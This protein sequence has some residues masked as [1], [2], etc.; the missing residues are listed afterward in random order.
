MSTHPQQLGKYEMRE[1][2]GRG[3]MAE[4]W[5]AF[6][7]QL[8]RYVA[9]KLMHAD[10]QN[11]PEFMTRFVREAR[12]IASLHHS[13][14]VQIYD[15]QTADTSDA[16]SPMAYMV[17]D[18]VEGQTLADYMRDTV[19]AGKFLTPNELV[20]LF[21]SISLAIDY[22]HRQGMLHRDIKPANILLD[23]RNT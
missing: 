17:M 7:T 8:H 15:F 11:D 12:A 9:I 10:L 23:K 2:L 3:G 5:K 20:Q 16:N 1:R 14:I 4:V 18:Y 13:N 21:T 22:A 6:D 19:R